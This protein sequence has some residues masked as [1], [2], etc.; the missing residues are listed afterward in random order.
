MLYKNYSL[1]HLILF[2]NRKHKTDVLIPSV[3]IRIILLLKEDMII[4][5]FLVK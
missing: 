1:S 5:D 2:R 3:S 4:K